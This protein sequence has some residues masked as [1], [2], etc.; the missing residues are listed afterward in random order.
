MFRSKLFTVLTVVLFVF[1]IAMIDCAVAGEKVK[2]YGTSVNTKWH[3]IEVGDEEGHVIAVSENKVVYFN[4]KTGEK[5]TQIFTA[6]WDFNTKTGQG[7][8]KGY[9]VM[10]SSNGDKRF[11]TSEGK[12]VGKGNFKGTYTYT[13]GTGKFEG[14]KGGGTWDSKSLAPG[15][16]YNEVEGEREIP[17]Q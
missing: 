5:A 17:G 6:T 9:G 11:S 12:P 2:A 10:T 4:E 8:L 14:L 13:G 3:Q 7:T 16:S 15:I 1:G